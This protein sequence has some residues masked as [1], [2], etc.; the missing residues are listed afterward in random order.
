MFKKDVEVVVNVR[1]EEEVEVEIQIQIQYRHRVLNL[2]GEMSRRFNARWPYTALNR[3]QQEPLG[4]NS[5]LL[6]RQLE[7]PQEQE[8]LLA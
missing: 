1:R 5:R 7:R 8:N 2:Y 4:D 3:C 6:R